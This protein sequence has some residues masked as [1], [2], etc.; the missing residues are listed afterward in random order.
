MGV[1]Q[2]SIGIWSRTGGLGGKK[3]AIKGK[4][5]DVARAVLCTYICK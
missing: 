3:E 2:G 5:F 1:H 4:M